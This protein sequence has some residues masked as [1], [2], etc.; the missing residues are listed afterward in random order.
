[1][2]NVDDVVVE[3]NFRAF[4]IERGKKVAGSFRE[5]HNVFTTTGRNW[6]SRLV[7]WSAIGGTD[8]P[9]TERRVR[10]IGVG[11]G[12]QLESA[13][14]T[15]LL[16]PLLISPTNYLRPINSVEFP[17]S[18]SVE[19][20]TE[21]GAEE[22]NISGLLVNVT[23]AALYAD[24]LPVNAGTEDAAANPGVVDSTLDP[25]VGTNPP[26]SYI[27]FEGIPKNSDLVLRIEW[28]YRFVG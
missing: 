6:L 23:E 5:G 17:S 7:A 19:F 26:I 20:I 25:G 14:V 27:A 1:M 4:L 12:S 15:S 21:L 9:F 18:T 16:Q 28:E 13:N 8:V 24:V 22:V 10:W 11:S 2:R 3:S